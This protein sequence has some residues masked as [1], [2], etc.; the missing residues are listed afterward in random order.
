MNTCPKLYYQ[1]ELN[2]SHLAPI[3]A[4]RGE[5]SARNDEF[6]H[7][8]RWRT[9]PQLISRFYNRLES[10]LQIRQ[11]GIYRI[12]LQAR[13]RANVGRDIWVR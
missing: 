3:V 9:R 13:E 1:L 10:R 8:I 11:V 6:R 7:I 4:R 5:P 12:R 2:P